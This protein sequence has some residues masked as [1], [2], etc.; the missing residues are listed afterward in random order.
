MTEH[1]SSP[2]SRDWT[3]PAARAVAALAVG[4]VV[5]FISNHSIT[6]GLIAAA[7][8]FGATTIALAVCSPSADSA[9]KRFRMLAVVHALAT[10]SAIALIVLAPEAWA[11][12]V[13]IALWALA[14]A[15]V[16]WLAAQ[17]LAMG[18]RDARTIA[19]G[20]AVFGILV[21][22]S[23]AL[24]MADPVSLT[25]LFAAFAAVVGVYHAIAAASLG[26]GSRITEGATN[27]T[28][29]AQS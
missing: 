27:D 21:A 29:E 20:T 9:R 19:I 13:L 22:L 2:R 10:V 7:V 15:A 26:F 16:E 28:A 18:S 25:G 8:F 4:L 11:F 3:L 1:T 5:P 14:S 17:S 23:P 12:V 6:V 24:G